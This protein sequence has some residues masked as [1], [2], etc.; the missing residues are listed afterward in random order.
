MDLRCL[1]FRSSTATCI[2]LHMYLLGFCRMSASPLSKSSCSA[3]CIMSCGQVASKANF[4][5]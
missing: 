2:F 5:L 4:R 1:T 3:C